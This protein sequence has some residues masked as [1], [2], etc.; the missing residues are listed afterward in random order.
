MSGSLGAIGLGRHY[1]VVMFLPYLLASGPI[2]KLIIL[3]GPVPNVE[4]GR[5]SSWVG[6]VGAI[7]HA[8][9]QEHAQ[10]QVLGDLQL[11]QVLVHEVDVE[12]LPVLKNNLLT[13]LYIS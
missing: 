11:R 6:A 3:H 4:V 12:K 10:E 8:S 5:H 13:N 9:H 1:Y 7:P 2:H